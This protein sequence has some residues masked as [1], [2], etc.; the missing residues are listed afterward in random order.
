M[1]GNKKETPI[2][3]RYQS[4]KICSLNV[5]SIQTKYVST[6]SQKNLY[7]SLNTNSIA[8]KSYCGKSVTHFP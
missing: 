2:F 6:D 7:C 3:G 8:K 4:L 1:L 5:G